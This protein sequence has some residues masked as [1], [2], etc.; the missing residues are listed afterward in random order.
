MD[1]KEDFLFHVKLKGSSVHG[2]TN[3]IPYS[4]YRSVST[5]QNTESQSPILSKKVPAVS[6]KL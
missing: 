4:L 1:R 3:P 5:L 6:L 2:S